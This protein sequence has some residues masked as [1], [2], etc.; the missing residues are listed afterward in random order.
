MQAAGL[1]THMKG[2]M[3]SVHSVTVGKRQYRVYRYEG[4]I[5]G[6]EKA[7]VLLSYPSNAFGDPV[8]LRA[9]LCTDCSMG[10]EEILGVYTERWPVEVFFRESK[11]TLDLDQYQIRSSQGIRRFWLLMS[12]AHF[13]CCT[14]S[15]Q[16]V[17]L[18]FMSVGQ[19]TSL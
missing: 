11:K 12:L 10:I 6:I 15:G 4:P 8:A 14:G 2:T 19:S 18:I 1:A 9:F 7:V 13:I 17:S 3:P 16:N 5:N